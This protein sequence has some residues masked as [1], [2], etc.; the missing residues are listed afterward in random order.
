MVIMLVLRRAVRPELRMA[1]AWPSVIRPPSPVAII[2]WWA[3]DRTLSLITPDLMT[4]VSQVK[5]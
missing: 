3:D 5:V 2:I 1:F 4:I